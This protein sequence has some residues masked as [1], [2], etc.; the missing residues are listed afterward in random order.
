MSHSPNAIDLD[1]ERKGPI[2]YYYAHEKRGSHHV[3]TE[4]KRID[5]KGNLVPWDSHDTPEEA[6]LRAWLARKGLAELTPIFVAK[7]YTD[8][9]LM[10]Q[11]GLEDADLNFLEI[12][13]RE[14]RAT[15]KGVEAKVVRAAGA[16]RKQFEQCVMSHTTRPS[17]ELAQQ[18]DRCRLRWLLVPALKR[19]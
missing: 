4:P 13:N 5:H 19:V 16:P 1:L 11:V 17:G 18:L 12:T 8:I 14:I 7:M 6:D 9:E 15:L 3:E 2:S 10:D